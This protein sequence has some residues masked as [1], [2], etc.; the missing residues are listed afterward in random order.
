MS[1]MT[2]RPLIFLFI[3]FFLYTGT[4]LPGLSQI[5]KLPDELSDVGITEKTGSYIPGDVVL[6]NELGE[7]VQLSEYLN[8]GRP[9]IL[10]LV[11]YECPSMCNFIMNSLTDV[12][13][14]LRWVAGKEFEVLTVSMAYNETWELARDNK[15]AY[16]GFLNREGADEG[17]HFLVGEK[18]EVKR[19]T[20]SV[21]FYYK[22]DEKTREYLHAS[23]L[24]FLDP[25][26]KV[27][28]YLYGIKYDELDIRNALYDAANGR[29]GTTAERV[30]LYCYTFDPDS[31]TYVP[32]AVNIM[33]IGG[34]LTL[35]GLGL[36]LGI[37]WIR[38]RKKSRNLP[39]T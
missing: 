3:L 16:T 9:F 39:S 38:E 33:K 10:N 8:K 25:E 11:Y 12:M 20:D 37:F 30:L 34:A 7:Q 35:L 26:G 6:T 28:R 29:I 23:A 21:G 1:K 18:D 22:W 17:W 19:L 14:E 13:K 4:A 24:I 27:S 32:Y 5:N 31:G 2:I 36:F 15:I